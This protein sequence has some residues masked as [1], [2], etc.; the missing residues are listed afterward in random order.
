MRNAM[1]ILLLFIVGC[2]SKGA[3]TQVVLQDGD[4]L[5]LTMEQSNPT[6]EKEPFNIVINPE[7][8]TYIPADVLGIVASVISEWERIIVE[9]LPD[10][11]QSD[12]SHLP[13]LF[14]PG[15]IDDL[16]I[17]LVWKDPA[18]GHDGVVATTRLTISRGDSLGLPFYAHI[19]LYDTYF[20]GNRLTPAQKRSAILHE[21]G[22]ALGFSE[23]YLSDLISD[24]GGTHYFWGENAIT[25]YRHVLYNYLGEKLAYGIPD[26]GVPMEE[27]L[28]H[29]KYP[30]LGWDIMQP[31]IWG[32]PIITRVTAGALA[33]LGYKVNYDYTQNPTH[34]LTK[35]AI[36]RPIFRC[37][38]NGL[39]RVVP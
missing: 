1:L 21:V 4:P 3:P 24:F 13:Y 16:Y 33:D 12:Y 18:V 19:W 14:P 32:S 2:G 11:P 22:H 35:P 30:A 27:G 15:K 23:Y 34:L 10:V 28:S 8:I 25:G 6:T 38:G 37:D 36:G 26:L 20:S 9:G 29:W 7:A 17:H 5:E 31:F 39:H